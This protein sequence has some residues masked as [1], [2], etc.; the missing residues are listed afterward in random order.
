MRFIMMAY[1]IIDN[2]PM[3]TAVKKLAF[4]LPSTLTP[5]NPQGH[6]QLTFLS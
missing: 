2:L 4:P 3:A 6:V 5:I 1:R